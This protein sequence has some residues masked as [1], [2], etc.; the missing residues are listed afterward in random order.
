KYPYPW[1]KHY[2]RLIKKDTIAAI[3]IHDKL[4]IEDYTQEFNYDTI[5]CCIQDIDNVAMLSDADMLNLSILANQINDLRF[6]YRTISLRNAYDVFLL[7]KKTSAKNAVN[8]VSRLSHPLNCFLAACGEVFNSPDSLTYTQTK[9]TN[10]YL[11]LFKEQ[12]TNS[13]N[14][15]RRNTRIKFYIHFKLVLTKFYRAVIYK[16][17]RI[18]FFNYIINVKS[19]SKQLDI[20]KKLLKNNR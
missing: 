1:S 19:Y 14:A 4:L 18:W 16:Q 7:S 20:W 3:E 13:R 10:V 11:K 6:H 15:K 2:T 9:K 17:Y 5:K 8:S 12:L